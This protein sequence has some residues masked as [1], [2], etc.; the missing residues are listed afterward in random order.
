[1]RNPFRRKKAEPV[2]E[3]GLTFQLSR[4]FTP[5]SGGISA[6]DAENKLKGDTLTFEA[7]LQTSLIF[8]PVHWLAE[9]ISDVP[10][11]VYQEDSEEEDEPDNSLQAEQ[12]RELISNNLLFDTAIAFT[13]CGN[14]YLE[15]VRDNLRMPIELKYINPTYVT[16]KANEQ[17]QLLYYKIKADKSINP[18]TSE[19]EVLPEDMI[20]IRK[21]TNP[22]NSLLG[23][24]PLQ[25]LIQE[26]VADVEASEIVGAVLR[27][28]GI[29]GL[30]VS[31]KERMQIKE[32]ARKAYQDNLQE[33]YTGMNRGKAF[34]SNFPVTLESVQID[35]DKFAL[36]AIHSLSAERV[37][38]VLKI[39]ASVI[40]FQPGLDQTKVG[41]TLR[42]YRFVAWENAVLPGIRNIL[43]A[44][45]KQI[46]PEFNDSLVYSYRLPDGHVALDNAFLLA[47][48]NAKIAE[49][50][51][52]N[53]LAGGI[54]LNEYREAMGLEPLPNGNELRQLTA[55]EV[56]ANE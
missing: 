45:N 3:K 31:P 25:S 38:V 53:Y 24:S 23:L 55:P 20:H 34:V 6:K 7:A 22:A 2:T 28:R 48:R 36:K 29:L 44:L 35:V 17:G 27:N 18:N 54:T 5:E 43:D 9:N 14:A 51:R 13:L 40:G 42:E 15:I 56:P 21:G 47:E 16:P 39:P 1:M 30:V 12:M 8:G 19:R 32:D 26:T 41:A 11:D 37:C 50:A 4:L 49:S 52:N 33:G 46:P 10:V